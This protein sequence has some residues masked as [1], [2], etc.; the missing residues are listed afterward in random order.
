MCEK[1]EKCLKC[2]QVCVPAC[3]GRLVIKTDL[4]DTTAVEVVVQKINLAS[5]QH[6]TVVVGDEIILDVDCNLF[7]AWSSYKIS[8]F[9]DSGDP[10]FFKGQLDCLNITVEKILP[11][12]T[13]YIIN[14]DC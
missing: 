4:P 13:E 11:E 7:Q 5:Y 14:T 9:D 3:V 1:C 12:P 10:V 8:F 6:D 2:C